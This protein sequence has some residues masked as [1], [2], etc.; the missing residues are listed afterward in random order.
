MGN[1]LQPTTRIEAEEDVEGTR[2]PKLESR[3]S[4]DVEEAH[5]AGMQEV[6][7]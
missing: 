5:V 1:A 6:A 4:S 2:P 3:D 7:G